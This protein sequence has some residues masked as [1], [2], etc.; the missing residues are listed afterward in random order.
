MRL[1]KYKIHQIKI[2]PKK[3]LYSLQKTIIYSLPNR[4]N[5]FT[6]P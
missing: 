2:T 4:N 5:A 6:K 3:S 1:Q